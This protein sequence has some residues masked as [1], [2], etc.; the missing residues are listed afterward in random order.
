MNKLVRIFAII[1]LI[2]SIVCVSL[3]VQ[4]Y[5]KDDVIDY[6]VG[7]HAFLGKKVKL[8]EN[9]KI[10]LEN[11]LK[12]PNVIITTDNAD[13]IIDEFNQAKGIL[14]NNANKNKIGRAHV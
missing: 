14:E 3:F 8:R 1:A 4:A 12:D 6:L 9:Y 13:T 11:Y 10:I 5:T 7:T 2:I